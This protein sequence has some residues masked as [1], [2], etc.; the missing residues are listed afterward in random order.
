MRLAALTAIWTILLGVPALAQEATPSLP[1][2]AGETSSPLFSL[3]EIDRELEAARSW[4][5]LGLVDYGSAQFRNVQIVLVSPDR[6][7]RRN[8]V[9]TVCGLVNSRNRMGGYTGFQPFYHGTALPQTWRGSVS[10]LA[11]DLCGRANRLTTVDYSDRLA[12]QGSS[13]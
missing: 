12:P 3:E 1:D 8:V 13:R 11:N 6:R 2:E 5:E 7:N 9:M 4:L 10:L